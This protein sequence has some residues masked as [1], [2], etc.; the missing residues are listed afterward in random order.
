MWHEYV[1]SQFWGVPNIATAVPKVVAKST[2]PLASARSSAD[3]EGYSVYST[4]PLSDIRSQKVAATLST[5]DLNTV[6]APL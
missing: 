5:N 1:N 4:P 3:A 2:S 6:N